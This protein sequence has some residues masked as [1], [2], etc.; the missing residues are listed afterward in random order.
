MNQ[1][2]PRKHLIISLAKSSLRILAG[3]FLC[4]GMLMSAGVLLIVAEVGGI[5]EELV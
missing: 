3:V 2:D 4:A 1:P 5:L